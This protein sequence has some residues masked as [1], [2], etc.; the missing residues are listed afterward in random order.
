LARNAVQRLFS[1]VSIAS[2]VFFRVAFG[3][4]GLAEV[5]GTWVH[6]HLG[7]GAFDPDRFQFYY[8]GFAWV[9]PLSEP[10]MSAFFAIST[11]AAAS[12]ALGWRYRFWSIFFFFSI[13]YQ[14]LLE[15]AHYL[16]HGYL[17][18]WVSFVMIFLPAHRAWSIDAWRR[19]T[20]R[21][22]FTP[23][24]PVLLLRFLMGVVY[25]YGGI[26]KINPDWLRA[27]PL[28]FWLKGKTDIP[29]IGRFMGQEWIAYLLSYGGLLLDLGIVFLL[30][31]RRT[32]PW[33][34]GFA[35]FFHGLNHLLFN[36]GIFPFL[37]LSLTL[38]FFPPD[39]PLRVWRWLKKYAPVL[40][41]LKPAQASS[42][43]DQPSP[44]LWQSQ[45]AWRR[46]ILL[47]LA[48]LC[49]FH[50]LVPLRHCLFP[51]DVTW[52]E[53]GHRYSWRMMLRTKVGKGHFVVIDKQSGDRELIYPRV[54]LRAKQAR[55]LFT[56]PDMIL[57]YA[58]YLRD[59]YQRQGRE[60]AVHAA[61][62]VRLNGRE[63]KPMVDP[64][65]DLARE[66]WYFFRHS[67]WIGKQ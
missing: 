46:P 17:F 10:W 6:Y 33:A 39:F 25:F 65:V 64:T 34:F 11:L 52:T 29:L 14:Y 53:E 5:S 63:Y 26:A 56:H 31:H 27:I 22:G 58:H 51:G 36:I 4:L 57:Q 42:A 19:P 44:P 47:S 55:K 43:P 37:S 16:N 40:V 2:L 9:R 61:I 30:L 62:Q 7:Q 45:A 28:K 12:I 18:C 24:W 66:K 20:W 38:L 21:S 67:P 60:V 49:A 32:R 23:F 54:E 35:I 50:L 8:Y 13:T 41:R 15:K 1:P 59:Q 3:L 48:A